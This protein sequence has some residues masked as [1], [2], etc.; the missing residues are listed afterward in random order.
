MR[1]R[2]WFVAALGLG[3]LVAL[4]A[5]SMLTSLGKSQ[6]IYDQFDQ[7]NNHYRR[8]DAN[9]RRLRSDVL[10]SG[11]FIRDYLLDVARERAPEYRDRL[12]EFRR[13]NVATL[14][15]LQTLI[16]RNDRIASLQS[17]LGDYWATFDPLF[18][19]PTAEKV[20]RSASFLRQEVVPR[21]EAV[22]AMAEE[23][24]ALNNANLAAQ[25]AEV[26]RR[27][28]IFRGDQQRRLWQTVLVGLI[29]A[30]IV[31]FR[32]RVLERRSDEAEHQMRELS[33]KLVSTQEEERRKLSRELH[34]HVAQ[35]LT[36]LKMELGRI[37]RISGSL[38]ER[39]SPLIAECKRL[40]D[41]MFHTVRGLALGLRPSMLDDF[42][43]QAALE[44]HIRDFM[45][46]YEMPVQ[47]TIE[48]DLSLLP[49]KH[50]TCVYRMVQEAMTNCVRHSGAESMQ[51]SV[52][53]HDGELEVFV[54]DDGVGL[55]PTWRRGGLGLRG[56]HERV[57]ELD[58]TMTISRSTRNGTLLSVRLPLPGKISGVPLARA[59]S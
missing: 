10:L 24:E 43:L 50:G 19:W 18:D 38:D 20:R 56:I 42:G 47:L 41:D 32:L 2:T 58:G 37:E 59:A 36:G 33:Q 44:W 1:L 27:Y 7:L 46:R 23:I 9:L 29:V 30:L 6:D 48:G 28:A 51:I 26:A 15:E 52:A 11:I 54:S 14:A 12:G 22:L 16:G 49:D 31:V 3:S 21:R 8:V 17:K 5:F 57:K 35:V 39:V 13:T 40:A 25:R 53:A 45:S 4:I 55:D 34:D